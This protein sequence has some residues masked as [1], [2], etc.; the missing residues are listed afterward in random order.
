MRNP[1]PEGP[2]TLSYGTDH[3]SVTYTTWTDTGMVQSTKYMS[4]PNRD[5]WWACATMIVDNDFDPEGTT[6]RYYV[7]DNEEREF[8]TVTFG[9]SINLGIHLTPD[10]ARKVHELLGEVLS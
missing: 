7:S 1:N 3:K 8:I 9:G 5:D 2:I 10:Q 4:S 6:V